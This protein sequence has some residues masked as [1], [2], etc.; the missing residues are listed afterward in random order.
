MIE[1]TAVTHHEITGKS[2]CSVMLINTLTLKHFPE[3]MN[4]VNLVYKMNKLATRKY[5]EL[6]TIM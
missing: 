2:A 4:E 5:E 3:V 1:R 6:S